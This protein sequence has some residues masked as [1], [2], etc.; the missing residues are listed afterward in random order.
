MKTSFVEYLLVKNGFAQLVYKST[1][2]KLEN[3]FILSP[4]I[5]TQTSGKGLPPQRHRDQP[6]AD[7][8]DQ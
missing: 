5:T 3:M 4:I 2:L 6:N 8:G 1:L 7:E